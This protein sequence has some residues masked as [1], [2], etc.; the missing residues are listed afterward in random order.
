MSMTTSE[1]IASR[2]TGIVMLLRSEMGVDGAET[3]GRALDV[4][5]DA[6]KKL[7][8]MQRKIW[9]LQERLRKYET[10]EPPAPLPAGPVWTGD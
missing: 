4:F 5:V 2:K 1:W 3:V 8:E 6:E 7:A 10:P 9:A